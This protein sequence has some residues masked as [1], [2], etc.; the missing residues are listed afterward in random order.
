M[1]VETTK[2]ERRTKF[3]GSFAL[4]MP[5]LN[6]LFEYYASIIDVYAYL[7]KDEIRVYINKNQQLLPAHFFG[8]TD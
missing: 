4:I 8:E 3:L 5:H 6:C 2:R 7:K 1:M